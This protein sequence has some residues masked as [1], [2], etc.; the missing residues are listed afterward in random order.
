MGTWTLGPGPTSGDD[1]FTGDSSNETAAS[2]EPGWALDPRWLTI[3]PEG[4]LAL[5]GR[6]A[7]AP[8]LR[9]LPEGAALLLEEADGQVER[10]V[11][12]PQPFDPVGPGLL[13]DGAGHFVFD[14]L[15][16]AGPAAARELHSM[17]AG[18][19]LDADTF[20]FGAAETSGQLGEA[21]G[22]AFPPAPD[23]LPE[24]AARGLH[25]APRSPTIG[26]E[27]DVLPGWLTHRP[28]AAPIPDP[29]QTLGPDPLNLG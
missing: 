7:A 14:Q 11:M 28:D 16:D 5:P 18:E 17:P 15:E 24:F 19:V 23:F 9:S 10:P 3:A 25:V 1:I 22:G 12:R 26:P 27:D 8:D 6:F 2:R 4:P 13:E 20:E 21:R 29:P